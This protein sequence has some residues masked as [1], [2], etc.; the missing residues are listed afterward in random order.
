MIFA[1]ERLRLIFV[2]VPK[3]GGTYVE[4]VLS[5]HYDFAKIDR[6]SP[7]LRRADHLDFCGGDLDRTIWGEWAYGIRCQGIVR[8]LEG[9]PAHAEIFGAPAS[10]RREYL[11]FSVVRCPYDR[12]VSAY[13]FLKGCR[14]HAI[15]SLDRAYM[16]SFALFVASADLVCHA[17]FCHAFIPQHEH[18]LGADGALGV[19]RVLRFEA[20][21]AE[22]CALLLERGAGE[23]THLRPEHAEQLRAPAARNP[24]HREH[25]RVSAY[26]GQAELDFVN[27]RFAADFAHFGYARY[28]TVAEMAAAEAAET[29]DAAPT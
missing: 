15:V 27:T 2:H 1:N 25:A 7:L 20:L 11:S 29:A 23:L 14:C 13:A 22:L 21:D 10:L 17:A 3:C 26:Y 8:Y 28:A 19:A 6:E 9:H 24:S 12:L 4:A 18:L 5:G 16:D